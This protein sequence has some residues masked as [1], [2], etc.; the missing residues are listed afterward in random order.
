MF[1]NKKNHKIC[2]NL[3]NNKI[4]I[5]QSTHISKEPNL[6]WKSKFVSNKVKYNL[7]TKNQ[8]LSQK[9]LYSLVK[10]R[11]MIKIQKLS[12]MPTKK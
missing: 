1:F 9:M 12:S 2:K 4:N 10:Q 3:N 6:I 11:L 5:K 8:Y 7:T